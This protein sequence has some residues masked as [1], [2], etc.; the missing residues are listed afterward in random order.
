MIGILVVWCFY[1]DE[2]GEDGWQAKV[3]QA[4]GCAGNLRMVI[5]AELAVRL[6]D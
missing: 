2:R 1:L 3:D 4:I 6:D 5:S